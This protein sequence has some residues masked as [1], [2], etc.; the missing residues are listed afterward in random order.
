MTP[1][2]IA[3]DG[4]AASGKSTIGKRLAEYL[5]YLF[6]DTGVM[7]R[8]ITW[9]AL[10]GGVDVSDESAIPRLAEDV[11]VDVRPPSQPDRACDVIV[12]LT[13]ITWETR[14]PEWTRT[15]RSSRPTRVCAAR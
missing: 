6:F 7:Y 3:I 13:D 8:A 14:R 5:G 15:S 1:S 2:I 10:R 9:I 4:P 11:F 12:G